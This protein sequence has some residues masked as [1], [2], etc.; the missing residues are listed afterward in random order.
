M[1]SHYRT[2]NVK[3]K[4]K[5]EEIKDQYR[6]LSKKYH[7]DKNQ[8]NKEAEE[9]FKGITAAYEVLSYPERRK[10]YDL[11]GSDVSEA[12]ISV[13]AG[14]L[15]Q[16]LFQ[17]V[18]S[19]KGLAE[20]VNADMIELVNKALDSGMVKLETNITTVRDSRKEIGRILKKLKHENKNNP[21]ALMLKQEIAKHTEAIDTSKQNIRI[22]KKARMLW[23]DYGFDYDQ[24]M[25]V[26]YRT[27][28]GP[29][30][31]TNM[32]TTTVMS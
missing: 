11:T 32:F 28:Y 3:Q 18:V 30:M 31:K 7:P 20:I 12:D 27:G 14:G 29:N 8:G 21:I 15:L 22:W 13:K 9:K 4:A 2:L 16:Q 1:L 10:N 17:N 19:R 26:N 23:K 25:K 24:K 6:E 5:P